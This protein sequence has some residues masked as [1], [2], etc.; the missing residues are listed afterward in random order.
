[1]STSAIQVSS[2]PAPFAAVGGALWALVPAAFGLVDVTRVPQSS[3]S[4]IAVLA[5]CWICGAA[6]LALLLAAVPG[7]RGALGAV[8][9]V[10]ALGVGVTA[11]GMVAM[12]L[13][14]GT[15]LTTITVAGSESDLG[16]TVFLIGFLV[17]IVGQVL[18]GMTVFRRRRDRLGRT[19][20][21]LMTLA[22]PAGIALLFLGGLLLPG[23]DVG[24]W[25]G[26]TVPTGVAW[27]L[28]GRSLATG[29]RPAAAAVPTV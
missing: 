11:V 7:V 26:I 25:A 19:A 16:H 22:L 13:G 8:G 17:A 27:L 6:S 1:V 9:R 3:L 28:L 24:F 15:E 4:S 12:L 10:G 5:G 18:L 20:G 29:R 2:R 23:T 14:N 21:L